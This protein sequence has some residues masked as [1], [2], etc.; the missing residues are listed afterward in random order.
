MNFSA[1]VLYIH[2]LVRVRE[3]AQP[4]TEKEVIM[5]L[6]MIRIDISALEAAYAGTGPDWA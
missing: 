4:E 5:Q 3:L 6:R 2:R 1:E